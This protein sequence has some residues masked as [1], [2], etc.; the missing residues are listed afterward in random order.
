MSEKL[1]A[2]RIAAEIQ[3]RSLQGQRR[4][5]KDEAIEAIEAAQEG[6]YESD[7][8]SQ[9]VLML[10]VA[11]DE[12]DEKLA[13]NNKPSVWLRKELRRFGAYVDKANADRRLVVDALLDVAECLNRELSAR[14]C[15]T[16]DSAPKSAAED[17]GG[18][19]ALAKANAAIKSIR[20]ER[21]KDE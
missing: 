4:K 18:L 13:E 15:C 2:K 11:L 10:L 8:K 16:E 19:D 3:N 1:E 5:W 12:A 6:I 14:G 9:R 7:P 21:N 17:Y 20:K